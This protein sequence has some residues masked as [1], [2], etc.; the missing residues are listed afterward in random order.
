MRILIVEDD[1]RIAADL[2]Q[3]LDTVGFRSDLAADGETAWF[4]GGT[5]DYGAIVLD[6][7]RSDDLTI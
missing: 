5:E 7:G 3:T 6:L 1:P 2:A 4:K